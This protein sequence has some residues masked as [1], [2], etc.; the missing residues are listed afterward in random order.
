MKIR[1]YQSKDEQQVIDLWIECGLTVPWNDAKKDIQ[2][3]VNDS[4]D[5]FF[6]GEI[7]GEIVASCMAGY[8]GH[9]GWIYFLAVKPT[10]QKRGFAKSILQYSEEAL[11]KIGCPKIELMVRNTNEKVISFYEKVGYINDP[12]VVLG[13]RLI[14]DD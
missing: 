5:M 6:V 10:Y 4:P 12:I 9:R 7:E 14:N 8:D 2:R 1:I 13:K 11:L 3:K